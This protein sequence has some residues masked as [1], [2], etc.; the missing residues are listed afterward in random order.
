MIYRTS[1]PRARLPALNG[2]RRCLPVDQPQALTIEEEVLRVRIVVAGDEGVGL[3]GVG[4]P[5]PLEAGAM[6]VQE[7]WSHPTGALEV[8]EHPGLVV[9]VVPV[10]LEGR[11]L[12]QPRQQ[13]ARVPGRPWRPSR[14]VRHRP[15]G[16]EVH[17]HDAR[18]GIEVS[19]RGRDARVR[20]DAHALVLVRVPHGARQHLD[21]NQV[22]AVRCVDAIRE[23]ARPAA[24]DR[25]HRSRRRAERSVHNRAHEVSVLLRDDRQIERGHGASPGSEV[26]AE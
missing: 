18:L 6:G 16:H 23:R 15:L 24:R 21:A 11:R 22:G 8:G 3:P 5:D 19:D 14:V 1:S 17:H 9:E 7:P 4:V 10:S 2:S 12:V 25:G 20:R 13:S 26:E